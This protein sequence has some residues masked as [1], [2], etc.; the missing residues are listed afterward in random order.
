MRVSSEVGLAIHMETVTFILNIVNTK[1]RMSL[2]EDV[3]LL[4]KVKVQAVRMKTAFLVG[5]ANRTKK[6]C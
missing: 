5:I 6:G 4:K 3:V 2:I 1:L